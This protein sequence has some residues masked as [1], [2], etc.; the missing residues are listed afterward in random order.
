MARCYPFHPQ[1]IQLAEQEWAKLAGY[2]RVRSTIRIFAATVFTL[3]K[4]AQEDQWTPLLNCPGD[5]PLFQR[6]SQGRPLSGSGLI[7]DT[8]IQANYRSL[9]SADIVFSRRRE[10]I[11]PAFLILP[12]AESS[13]PT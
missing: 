5:L 7:S 2:Q 6:G 1:L 9:A 13:T 3:A 11:R 12:A 10:R 4:R 8:R